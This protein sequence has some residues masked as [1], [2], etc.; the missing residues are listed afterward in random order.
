MMGGTVWDSNGPG[1]GGYPEYE[2]CEEA[3]WPTSSIR[4]SGITHS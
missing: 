2:Q 1:Q 4:S 3:E